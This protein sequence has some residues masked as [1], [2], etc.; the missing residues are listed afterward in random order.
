MQRD[1]REQLDHAALIIADGGTA[2]EIEAETSL[3]PDD[4]ANVIWI[5]NERRKRREARHA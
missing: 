3:T 1:Y 4:I 2:A 5:E